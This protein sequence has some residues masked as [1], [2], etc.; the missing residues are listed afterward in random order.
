MPTSLK[1]PAQYDQVASAC[2]FVI[3]AA[4]AC[5][6]NDDALFKIQ[7]ACDEACTNVIEHAY[8]EQGGE[9]EICCDTQESFFEIYI[10]DQGQPFNPA[11]VPYPPTPDPE[12]PET[13]EIGGLGLHF[14]RSIM[15]EVHFTGDKQ[16][17]LLVMRKK[18]PT[19]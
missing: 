16:G 4:A 18:L 17:N 1:I 19:P 13:L 10:R 6:F 12:Q 2:Q 8:L 11:D 5:G 7:L 9:I 3:T 15:D 14:M